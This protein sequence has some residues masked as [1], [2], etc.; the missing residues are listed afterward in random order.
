MAFPL[1]G[2]LFG[3]CVI[4]LNPGFVFCCDPREEVLVISDFIQQ[5]LANINTRVSALQ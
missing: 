1:R 2:L 4:I 5:F 3:F